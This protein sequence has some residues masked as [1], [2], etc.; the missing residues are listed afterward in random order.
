[1][2][3]I[4]VK[5]IWE[6]K[7][8][9]YD[10][11]NEYE[12]YD[13]D[14]TIFI[15]DYQGSEEGL[16]DNGESI[17]ADSEHLNKAKKTT[18][19]E[20]FLQGRGEYGLAD[21][22]IKR[23][24]T[25]TIRSEMGD[26]IQ[27]FIMYSYRDWNQR[28]ESLWPNN[29]RLSK[30]TF[31]AGYTMIF[32]L[33]DYNSKCYVEFR[34]TPMVDDDG[35]SCFRYEELHVYNEKVDFATKGIKRNLDFEWIKNGG[36][37]GTMKNVL[38]AFC[39]K[40]G[41]L[42]EPDGSPLSDIEKK[43]PEV[44]PV[45][46]RHFSGDNSKQTGE[47][48]I[49]NFALL[50]P[51]G[52]G[53]T[54]LAKEL[55]KLYG[56]EKLHSVTP[57][58]LKGSYVGQTRDQIFRVF[59]DMREKGE[60][61]LLID[62]V[63]EL[64]SDSY[65]REAASIL[66]P[67][68]SGD[69][70]TIT[71]N[72]QKPEEKPETIDVSGIAIWIAG[73]DLQTR[74]MLQRNLGLYRRFEILSLKTPSV[75]RLLECFEE[76]IDKASKSYEEN[77]G[78]TSKDDGEERKTLKN[79]WEEVKE[80]VKNDIANF[81]CWAIS[82]ERSPYFA[83]Y[84]G[85][86]KLADSIIAEYLINKDFKTAV[87]NIISEMKKEIEEQFRAALLMSKDQNNKGTIELPAFKT[88]SYI[89]ETEVIGNEKVKKSMETIADMIFKKEEYAEKGISIPKGVLFVGP[90]GT[91][92]SYMAKYMAWLVQEKF[93]NR[94][95]KDHVVG[96]IPI[97]ATELDSQDKVDMLFAE[98][99]EFDDCIIFIDEIDAIGKERSKNGYAPVLLRLMTQM[100]GFD[101][102]AGIFILAATNAPEIL[103][104]A[105]T[106]PGR[107]D[108]KLEIGLPVI[109]D[110]EE[111]LEH[112]LGKVDRWIECCDCDDEQKDTI[113]LEIARQT[114]GFSAAMIKT[115]VNNAAIAIE[116][117]LASIGGD[118]VET[119]KKELINQ[120]DTFL[121]GERKAQDENE[122]EFDAK[123]NQGASGT[124]VHEVGHALM[125]IIEY[126]KKPFAEITVLPRG[127]AL[128]YVKR[129]P[130]E[131]GKVTYED[132]L[133]DVRI[134]LG[135]RIAEELI[136]GKNQIGTGAVQDIREATSL[137]RRMIFEWGMSDKIGPVALR[138][139]DH[140]YLGTNAYYTCSEDIRVE[141]EKE[142][143]SIMKEQYKLCHDILLENKDMLKKLAEKV[144]KEKTMSG[145]EF[146]DEYN[147]GNEDANK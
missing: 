129:T 79:V 84:A 116:E 29:V 78:E 5:D 96:F 135:G 97:T 7:K 26:G 75:A 134:S 1:M 45:V 147:K 34:L 14:P 118:A 112:Y 61:I 32:R 2:E 70:K 119:W 91:G 30:R 55:A 25:P 108:S 126:G 121:I 138:V 62:E 89:E 81:V 69:C 24:Q 144:F 86:T 76:K 15:V 139:T 142:V 20:V 9:F 140:N 43:F 90:P 100:D 39:R 64:F 72:P 122:T 83:N 56:Q 6:T 93:K 107:F 141:A 82:P 21:Y 48:E 125:T 8:E 23:E 73:Y 28:F 47:N 77:K 127:D 114:S 110:R 94:E 101:T 51:A 37:G 133:K 60:K 50:G 3:E 16:Y 80:F 67:L 33:C 19:K 41:I 95:K 68:M 12:R 18:L 137:V 57:S 85:I 11:C 117:S 106:R 115:I 13:I 145:A 4:M 74:Q 92:K 10:M 44:Y 132:I 17:I 87:N 38:K 113:I 46:K 130:E 103:D 98:A 71:S 131:T 146:M 36:L 143:M 109:E 59:K 105:L 35:D 40:C 88:V 54:T 22:D 31:Y 65:G 128:G 49:Q 63:Y 102:K 136:Y 123:N 27:V 53:K 104:P 58:D 42:V 124:A 120:I 52:V 66:L 111:L 99:K